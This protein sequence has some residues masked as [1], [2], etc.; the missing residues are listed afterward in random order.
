MG[1]LYE[2]QEWEDLPS[3]N[4]PIQSERLLHIEQGIYNASV[5]ANQNSESI[6]N[7]SSYENLDN[8][9]KINGVELAGDT[10]IDQLGITE[11]VDEKILEAGLYILEGES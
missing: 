8:K 7:L 2:M 1:E 6:E 10:S 9:P 11:Y 5:L 3:R 4:T